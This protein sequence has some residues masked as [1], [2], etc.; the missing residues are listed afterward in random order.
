[1][2][3]GLGLTGED[4]VSVDLSSGSRYICIDA[5]YVVLHGVTRLLKSVT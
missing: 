4:A 3:V 1:V 5:S 2:I